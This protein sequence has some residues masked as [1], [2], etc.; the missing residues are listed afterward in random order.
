M[1]KLKFSINGTDMKFGDICTKAMNKAKT[2][3]WSHSSEIEKWR[4][5]LMSKK[6]LVNEFNHFE[7]SLSIFFPAIDVS[8]EV[9]RREIDSI[10]AI[11]K[12]FESLS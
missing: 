2:M 8:D 12:G 3:Y 7:G 5:G 4:A 6:S 9:L 10:E 1:Q 11:L